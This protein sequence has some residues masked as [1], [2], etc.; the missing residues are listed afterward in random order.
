M[1]TQSHENTSYRFSAETSNYV[2][3]T[4][5]AMAAFGFSI[6]PFAGIFVLA[7]H[8]V[9]ELY[10]LMIT[11]EVSQQ[12]QRLTFYN[13]A[14]KQL[15]TKALQLDTPCS[16]DEI[17]NVKNIFFV[18]NLIEE[19]CYKAFAEKVAEL[20]I[21]SDVITEDQAGQI[22]AHIKKQA[23]VELRKEGGYSRAGR[24]MITDDQFELVLRNIA[25]VIHDR[26]SR[27]TD[28]R[29]STLTDLCIALDDHN[30]YIKNLLFKSWFRC[31]DMYCDS[32]LTMIKEIVQF[33]QN[34]SEQLGFNFKEALTSKKQFYDKNYP[35]IRAI[36]HPESGQYT[37]ESFVNLSEVRG[38]FTFDIIE[39]LKQS[40]PNDYL[41]DWLHLHASDI[42]FGPEALFEPRLLKCQ[43]RFHKVIDQP[44]LLSSKMTIGQFLHDYFPEHDTMRQDEVI[45]KSINYNI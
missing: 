27:L 22:L 23:H 42:S 2:R 41:V 12:E 16:K 44:A 35:N 34:M 14:Y 25:T 21:T 1:P 28:A 33:N 26:D 20:N 15:V 10:G 45:Q 40:N 11:P 24:S 19:S 37:A 6:N 30:N 38:K 9:W 13:N 4:F 17:Q 39:G 32:H 7:S 5:G 31:S 18:H 8:A 43:P 29:Y 36:I 3:G